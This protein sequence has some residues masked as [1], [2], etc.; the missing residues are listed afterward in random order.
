MHLTSDPNPS[1][2]RA[3]RSSPTTNRNRRKKAHCG[4]NTRTHGFSWTR[5]NRIGLDGDTC[6]HA[7]RAAVPAAVEVRPC[8]ARAA[9][10]HGHL[11][12]CGGVFQSP[13]LSVAPQ[14]NVTVGGI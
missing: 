6:A 8:W 12:T 10:L 2:R 14:A 9:Y 5:P 3:L 7:C 4:H 13:R 11:R 1:D